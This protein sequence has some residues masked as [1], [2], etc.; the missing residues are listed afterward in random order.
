MP[1]PILHRSSA[2]S[3]T[4]QVVNVAITG[5]SATASDEQARLWSVV[6]VGVGGGVN[7][8]VV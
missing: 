1:N 4:Y 6:G 5:P 2:I 8:V 7:G 3:S